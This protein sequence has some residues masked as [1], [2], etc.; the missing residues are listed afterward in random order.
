MFN[1][2]EYICLLIPALSAGCLYSH[3]PFYLCIATPPLLF[4]DSSPP[5][6]MEA[7]GK[8]AGMLSE[9][10]ISLRSSRPPLHYLYRCVFDVWCRGRQVDRVGTASRGSLPSTCGS[11]LEMSPRM[12]S[13]P[14]ILC[15]I[16]PPVCTSPPATCTSGRTLN[17]RRVNPRG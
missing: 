3:H 13:I 8:R 11:V 14:S 12:L 9:G 1:Y 2:L 10:D 7:P 16:Q 6:W 17:R 4:K 15:H 5:T